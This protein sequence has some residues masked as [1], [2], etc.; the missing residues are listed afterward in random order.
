MSNK[1][2]DTLM[3]VLGDA[4]N[5]PARGWVYLPEDREWSLDSKCAVLESEEVPPGLEDKPNAGVPR[6]AIE[7]GLMQAV[8]MSVMQDIV[9][10]ALSQKPRAGL[11]D[12][13]RAFIFYWE[14]DA[15]ISL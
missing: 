13:L 10:N 9:T 7:N 3:T 2:N 14:N 6:W 5:R 15:F 11:E 8:P 12:L 1:I 4:L